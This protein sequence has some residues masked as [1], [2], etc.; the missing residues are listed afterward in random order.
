MHLTSTRILNVTS[1]SLLNH[2][3]LTSLSSQVLF[4]SFS[5]RRH[6]AW[7][8]R[9]TTTDDNE[10]PINAT[11]C[12]QTA[13]EHCYKWDSTIVLAERRCVGL[14]ES[15]RAYG[16]RSATIK[17]HSNLRTAQFRC[18][19]IQQTTVTKSRRRK[20]FQRLPTEP[21]SRKFRSR[22][23]KW[24]TKKTCWRHHELMHTHG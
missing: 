10:C 19:K 22:G 21:T 1:S 24:K 14:G 4:S 2:V 13:D 23:R 6:F 5:S 9:P 11:R 7:M 18:R 16:E 20:Q 15:R 17:D 12:V 8:C 3:R